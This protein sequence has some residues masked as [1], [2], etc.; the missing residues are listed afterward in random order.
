[1]AI[2]VDEAGAILRLDA[3]MGETITLRN[4]VT[5]KP[6]AQRSPVT[7]HTQPLQT[8]VQLTARVTAAPLPGQRQAIPNVTP[9]ALTGAR[10]IVAVEDWLNDRRGALLT[11]SGLHR[12][13]RNLLLREVR[14]AST[15]R[16]LVDLRID[17][18]EVVTSTTETVAIP[19]RRKGTAEL[20]DDDDDGGG[21]GQG[22]R[23]AEEPQTSS[24]LFFL[25][26][27]L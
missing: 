12:V 4:S 14:I 15:T 23:E 24:F 10:R 20:A 2:L 6:V 26:S 18:V 25:G 9:G 27:A 13:R 8:P 1:M 16:G 17:L 7:D 3:H 19:A 21:G 22:T 11:F 5:T